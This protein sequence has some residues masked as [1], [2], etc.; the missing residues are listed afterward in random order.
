MEKFEATIGKYINELASIVIVQG[1]AGLNT[2][3][4]K[5]QVKSAMAAYGTDK[6]LVIVDYV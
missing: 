6:A 3:R 4:L 2:A 1:S 5:E